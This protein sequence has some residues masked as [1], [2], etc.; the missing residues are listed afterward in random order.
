[1]RDLAGLLVFLVVVGAIV[2]GLGGLG[3]GAIRLVR[4]AWEHP[5]AMPTL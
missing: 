2:A 3:W 1:M 5:L 4:W